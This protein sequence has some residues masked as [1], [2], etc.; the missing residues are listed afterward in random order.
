MLLILILVALIALAGAAFG[1]ISLRRR[2]QWRLDWGR[3]G[4]S[5]R[6]RSLY[7]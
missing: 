7:E 5:P 1:L 2:H 3:F 4:E 6:W